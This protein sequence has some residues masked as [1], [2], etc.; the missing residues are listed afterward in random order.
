MSHTG[1]RQLHKYLGYLKA[2]SNQGLRVVLTNLDFVF[3]KRDHTKES[4]ISS[5]IFLELIRNFGGILVIGTV[6][7]VEETD[8]Y[9]M[10]YFRTVIP[11]GNPPGILSPDAFTK[12]M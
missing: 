8:P 3:A 7:N 11:H 5:A 12:C 6:R 9:I 10:R 4:L 1:R 2:H